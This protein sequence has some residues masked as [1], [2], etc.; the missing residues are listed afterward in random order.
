M[1]SFRFCKINNIM[2]NWDAWMKFGELKGNMPF[3]EAVSVFRSFLSS[4]EQ[5]SLKLR[6]TTYLFSIN[7]GSTSLVE[8][9]SRDCDYD[10]PLS[11]VALVALD[12]LDLECLTRFFTQHDLMDEKVGLLGKPQDYIEAKYGKPDYSVHNSIEYVKDE[13]SVDFLFNIDNKSLCGHISLVWH[14]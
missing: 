14:P 10:S 13:F 2:T 8:F 11:S 12:R 3:S 1:N 9:S 4:E 6:K 7:T 5:G